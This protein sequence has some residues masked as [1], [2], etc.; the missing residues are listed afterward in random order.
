M[1]AM[2]VIKTTRKRLVGFL[3]EFSLF[4]FSL[5]FG[6]ER[7][8]KSNKKREKKSVGEYWVMNWVTEEKEW[9]VRVAIYNGLGR[10]K[11]R[12]RWCGSGYHLGLLCLERPT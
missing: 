8:K 10:K 1:E 4:S 7:K 11:R 6:K 9:W 3:K 5:D 12:C 2:D